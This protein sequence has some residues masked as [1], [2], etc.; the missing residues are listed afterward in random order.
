[1]I[2]D[3][4]KQLIGQKTISYDMAKEVMGE[5]MSG[6]ASQV[7]MAAYLSALA[8]IGETIDTITASAE[9]MRQYAS[10]VTH[11]FKDVFEIVGTGGDGAKSFNI[12]TT[13]A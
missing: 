10:P 3:A 7:Q 2:I 5:M 6:T 13:S 8:S 12:S 11:G 1:M 4:T 9:Q